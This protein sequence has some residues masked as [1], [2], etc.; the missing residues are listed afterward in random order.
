MHRASGDGGFTLTEMLVVISLL[1]IVL[2]AAY[3][4]IF[5]ARAGQA[6]SDREAALSRAVTLPLLSVERLLVQNSA[7]DQSETPSHNKLMIITNPSGVDGQ[8]EQ[9]TFEAVQDPATGLGYV[10]LTTYKLTGGVRV[11]SAMQNGHISSDNTN[12]A[13]G[14]YLFRYYDKS[15]VEITDM[16]TVIQNARSVLVQMRVLVG[17]RHETHAD[18]IY[19]RNRQD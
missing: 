1:G 6:N 18:T 3:M 4:F 8:E 10:N 2:F 7:I 15:G 13:D 11:G 14:V 16:S 12:I 19:F 9:N 5:A 17:G